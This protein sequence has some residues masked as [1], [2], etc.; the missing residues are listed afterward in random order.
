KM[1]PKPNPTDQCLHITKHSLASLKSG[2]ASSTMQPSDSNTLCCA[3]TASR[4]A[5][6]HGSPRFLNMA[7]RTPL[8]SRPANEFANWLP[9]WSM[10]IGERRSNPASTLKKKAQ[11]LTL[12][13]TG[14]PTL[15][16]NHPRV[17]GGFGTRPGEEIG[18]A[19]V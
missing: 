14:P 17:V 1:S 4:T 18:R 6:S 9:S 16:V 13:A 8:K 12:R 19:H 15:K 2:S 5:G 11:S 3:L 7:T 10:E